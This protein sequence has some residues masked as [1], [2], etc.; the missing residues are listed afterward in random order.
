M[1]LLTNN[2][3]V[4]TDYYSATSIQKLLLEQDYVVMLSKEDELWIINYIWGDCGGRNDVVFI[5]RQDYYIWENEKS[6][7][8]CGE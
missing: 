5:S 1:E 3:I 4:C 6:N 7:D 2:E 8:E